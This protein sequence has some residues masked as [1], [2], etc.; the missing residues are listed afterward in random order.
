VVL[1]ATAEPP[2]DGL[3]EEAEV[4]R[5]PTARRV[6]AVL[7]ELDAIRRDSQGG[8]VTVVLPDE[9]LSF[10][11]ELVVRPD[12]IWLKLALIRRHNVVAASCPGFL[13]SRGTQTAAAEPE[14]VLFVPVAGLDAVTVN[15]L[16]YARAVSP[17][18]VAVHVVTEV[19]ERA[20]QELDDLPDQFN[21]WA[22]NL[23]GDR[24]HLVVI[25]SPYRSVVPPLV[26]YILQWRASH[27]DRV[28]TAVVPELVDERLRTLWL[29]NHR[30]FW[31]K[32]ALLHEPGIGVIDV[33]LHIGDN[34][35]SPLREGG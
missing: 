13:D 29:H 15:A 1:Q 18:V 34:N 17:E 31:L 28:C 8:I 3:P 33:T 9:A 7:G 24:P 27:P 5:L 6:R 23:D 19:Q 2:A 22:S 16:R 25:E 11:V 20:G 26:S 35:P 21:Q 14:H 10:W 12:L 30:A 32:A 4:R